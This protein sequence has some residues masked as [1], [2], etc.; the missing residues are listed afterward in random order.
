MIVIKKSIELTKSQIENLLDF[1][2]FNFIESIR[3]DPDIDEL[4]YLID[5]CEVVTKL[6]DAKKEIE[7]GS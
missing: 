2:E 3:N 7:R 6:R 4:D 1:F 5:I